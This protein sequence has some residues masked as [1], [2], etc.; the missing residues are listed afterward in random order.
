MYNGTAIKLKTKVS[1]IN[2]LNNSNKN[3]V[4]FLLE[5]VISFYR[6]FGIVNK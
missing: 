4:G 1:V 6:S 2:L 5:D 3:P